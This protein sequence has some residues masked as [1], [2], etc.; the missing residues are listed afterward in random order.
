MRTHVGTDAGTY[1]YVPATSTIVISGLTA[2]IKFEDILDILHVPTGKYLYQ[3]GNQ[4]LALANIVE[5]TGTATLKLN[6]ALNLAGH[7]PQDPL[8][9]YISA[10]GSAGGGGGG[11]DASAANQATQITRA[12]EIRDRLRQG[13]LSRHPSIIVPQTVF[14]LT[15][16]AQSVEVSL[17]PGAEISL[18]ISIPNFQAA[19]SFSVLFDKWGGTSWTPCSVRPKTLIAGQAAVTSATDFGLWRYTAEDNISKVR[20]TLD[21]LVAHPSISVF[22]DDFE[23]GRKIHIPFKGFVSGTHGLVTNNPIIP[24]INWDRLGD[25]TLDVFA[26][27]GTSQTLT[28]Q[29]TDDDAGVNWSGTEANSKS[30]VTGNAATGSTTAAGRYRLVPTAQYYRVNFT[31]ATLTSLN[32]NGVTARVISS[33]SVPQQIHA[34]IQGMAADGQSSNGNAVPI[35]GEAV[36]TAPAAITAGRLYK[37]LM[38][39]FRRLLCVTHLRELVDTNVLTL[40]TTTETQIIASVASVTHDIRNLVISNSG[41]NGQYV[42]IRPALASAT[43]YPFYIAAGACEPMPFDILKQ[44]AQNAAWTVQLTAMP[45]T[46]DVRVVTVSNRTR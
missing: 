38:D 32:I 41:T 43:I 15:A 6:P 39:S 46:G 30:V 34:M 42:L 24:A 5:G 17:E 33:S 12:T 26:L 45:T 10:P 7:A 2:D 40:T 3:Q 28:W 23:D 27:A 44:L 29:E 31:F 22:I 20:V 37:P 18:T 9:I 21:T 14:S 4:N 1:T 35:A 19:A 16:A 36:T 8:A 11:G 13:V 25:T